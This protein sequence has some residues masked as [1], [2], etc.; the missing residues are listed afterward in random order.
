MAPIPSTPDLP[1]RSRLDGPGSGPRTRPVRGGQVHLRR[2]GVGQPLLRDQARTGGAG[3]PFARTG[4]LT[5][6]TMEEGE[7]LG[8]SWLVPPYRYFGD[9]RAVTPVSATALDGDCLRGK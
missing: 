2:G 1:R 7:V 8:W 5:I 3:D 6:D 4:P 9:A